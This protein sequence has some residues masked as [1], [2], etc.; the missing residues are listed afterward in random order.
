LK[1]R[2]YFGITVTGQKSPFLSLIQQI[3]CQFSKF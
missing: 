1:V 2:N 3:T